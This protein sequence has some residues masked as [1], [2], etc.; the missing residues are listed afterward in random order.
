MERTFVDKKSAL[1]F[2]YQ[3]SPQVALSLEEQKKN[4]RK[5]GYETKVLLLLHSHECQ[6]KI[7]VC[8]MKLALMDK[9][10]WAEVEE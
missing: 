4:I 5:N 10:S 6:L 3:T 8:L 2:D 7:I 1:H 9:R